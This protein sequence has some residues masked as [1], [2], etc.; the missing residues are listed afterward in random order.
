[1]SRILI[2]EDEVPMRTALTDTLG[3]EGY[4]ILTAVDGPSGLQRAVEEK[5]DL[6]LLDVMMPQMDGF[7]VCRELRR[8]GLRMPVLMLTAR[9][10]TDDKVTG[11]DAGADDYLVKPFNRRELLARVR[12]LLRR[13]ITAPPPDKITFG[14]VSLDFTR[15]ECHRQG[16]EIKLTPKE[17]AM[18]RLLSEQPGTV[19]TRE[20][21][22]DRVWGYGSYPVTRTVDNHI[23]RL[24]GKLED[25]PAAPRFILTAN[26]AGYRLGVE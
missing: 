11:L 18:L 4:R 2:V 19:V 22:L 14:D 16:R 26:K 10:Q 9:G 23:A 1:M 20:D 21:F 24:R 6:V 12:A 7:A 5:P 25:D 3:D 13:T 8:L 15:G 17:L